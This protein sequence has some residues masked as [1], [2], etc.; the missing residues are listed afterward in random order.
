M[1]KTNIANWV[2]VSIYL[3][4]DTF[5]LKLCRLH[6]THIDM[7]LHSWGF[8]KMALCERAIPKRIPMYLVLS[9]V[10]EA[11]EAKSQT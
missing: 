5:E 6:Q 11:L 4:V 3:Y 2:I 7:L 10:P 9:V 1:S 8:V